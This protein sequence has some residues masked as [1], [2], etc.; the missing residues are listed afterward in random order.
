VSSGGQDDLRSDFR[1]LEAETAAPGHL[2]VTESGVVVGAGDVM[3]GVDVDGAR[4]V[5]VPTDDRRDPPARLYH[6]LSLSRRELGDPELSLSSYL[7]L[8]NEAPELDDIFVSVAA[9]VLTSLRDDPSNPDSTCAAVVDQFRD[10]FARGQQ[11]DERGLAWLFAEL[12]VLLMIVDA[13][14]PLASWRGPLRQRHD[15]VTPN[16]ALEVKSTLSAEHRRFR[17]HGLRQL[18]P[19]E[20]G[21]LFLHLVRIE[22][23]LGGQTVP[24]LVDRLQSVVEVQLLEE[25]LN[26]AGYRSADRET[27]SE[28]GFDV[29]DEETHRVGAEFPRLTTSDVRLP[30]GV[31]TI[32]YEVDLSAVGD[33]GAVGI[34]AAVE[35]LVR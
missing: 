18:E 15:F 17:V 9:K 2:R 32:T 7:V 12:R 8:R 30:A 6:G 14:G 19:P 4:C 11:L 5:L 34:E 28:I 20:S 29:L 24:Q 33:L 21:V 27:Y 3:L 13:G 1:R 26:A 35:E 23:A 31:T 16:G 10:L 25:L 22:P